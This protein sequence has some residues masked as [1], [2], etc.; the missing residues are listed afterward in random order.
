MASAETTGVYGGVPAPER[1]AERR[2]RLLD[3]G[4]DVLGSEGWQATTVR[5]IC[6]RAKLNPRYFYESF[7]GLDE[8]LVAVFDGIAEQALAAALAA[9]EENP[10]DP[11]ATARAA[12]AGFVELLTGDPRMGRVA[13]VEAMGSEALMRRRLDTLQQAAEIVAAYGRSLD[14]DRTVDDETVQLT[15]QMLVGGLVEALIAWFEGRLQVSRERLVE[16]CAAMFVAA[17]GVAGAPPR[18]Y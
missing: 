7:S 9:I 1:R 12:I 17:M 13:V 3:A 11:E 18:V 10:G 8:L 16:H 2:R 6:D 4:L 15:A 5:G 14:P